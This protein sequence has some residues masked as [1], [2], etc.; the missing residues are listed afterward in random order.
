MSAESFFYILFPF[1]ARARRP[2]P[3]GSNWL[4]RLLYP[5]R[6]V[7]GLLQWEPREHR[8]RLLAKLAVLWGIGMIPGAVYVVMQPDGIAHPDRW[9]WGPWLQVLKFTPLPHLASFTFGIVL[10]NLDEMVPRAG[11]LRVVLGV[12]GFLAI[13][14]ILLQGPAVPYPMVHDGL[15]MP[16]FACIVLGLAGQNWLARVFSWRLFVFVGEASY[17][18]YLLHF[19]LWQM[20]QN[21]QILH[22]LW[23]DQIFPWLGERVEDLGRAVAAFAPWLGHHLVSLGDNLAAFNIAY[24]AVIVLA[25]LAL[26]LVEKPAQRVL[27]GWMHVWRD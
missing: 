14:F 5:V 22:R 13:F 11:R 12:G 3:A 17:C 15:L 8:G 23:L 4:R 7:V 21:S 27:R 6:R 18:L 2:A 20:M 26:Y 19:N 25:L 24:L 1:L 16:F 9:S 10:A